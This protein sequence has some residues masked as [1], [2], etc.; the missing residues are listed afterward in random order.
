VG[1]HKG[2]RRALPPRTTRTAPTADNTHR[3]LAPIAGK[4]RAGGPRASLVSGRLRRFAV[5]PSVLGVVAMATAF[6]GVISSQ[7]DTDQPGAVAARPT[8]SIGTASTRQAAARRQPIVS[9]GSSRPTRDQGS[10][11]SLTAATERRAIER[12]AVLKKYAAQAAAQSARIERAAARQKHAAQAAAQSARIERDRWTLPVSYVD[13]T[14]RFGDSGLWANL[15]TGLDF[16]GDEGDPIYSV[17]TGT[18]TAVGYDGAYGNK[19][20]VTLKDGTEIWYCHQNTLLVDLGEE[21]R[22]GDQI[23]TIGS[24]GNVTGSHLH[25]EVRPGGGDPIDP[26]TVFAAKGLL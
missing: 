9:R 7:A 13:L 21:V 14:A 10:L 17:A 1:D 19:T 3:G 16:N 23:G 2:N 24:T 22:G 15:H 26:F 11:K 5:G 18:V 8:A 6:T 4:R 25:L 20:V 12:A